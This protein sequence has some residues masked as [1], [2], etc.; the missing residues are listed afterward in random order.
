MCR[1][2]PGVD[3]RRQLNPRCTPLHIHGSL[4][5]R[6]GV[7]A[8]VSPS[9]FP[10]E[11]S[12]AGWGRPWMRFW[13]LRPRRPA[14]GTGTEPPPPAVL[15]S[16]A[17]PRAPSGVRVANS[18]YLQELIR[19]SKKSPVSV[20]ACGKR[21]N[22]LGMG[23][24]G[25]VCRGS[26]PP[27]LAWG[28]SG[29]SSPGLWWAHPARGPKQACWILS[30]GKTWTCWGKSIAGPRRWRA[31]GSTCPMKA[32][33]ERWGCSA[34]GREGSGGNLQ[35][36]PSTWRGLQESQRLFTRDKW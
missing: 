20:R 8:G 18:V 3:S 4:C 31:G 22:S 19:P 34:C 30:T 17:E 36:L 7:P 14:A 5:P 11:E 6:Q 10:R 21:G 13:A 28:T 33:W 9:F 24:A 12:T 29:L 25:C 16:K 35:Q 23:D 15:L 32:G 1:M 2:R 26:S 27:H